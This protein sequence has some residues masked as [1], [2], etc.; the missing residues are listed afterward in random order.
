MKKLIKFSDFLTDVYFKNRK[1]LAE[2]TKSNL[3]SYFKN[4]L[5]FYNKR[6]LFI[7]KK[8]ILTWLE[9]EN[10]SY[11]SHRMN[12]NLYYI[13]EFAKTHKY[14]FKN[15]CEK[16]KVKASNKAGK[17]FTKVEIEKILS[18][19]KQNCDKLYRACLLALYGGLRRAEICGLKWSEVNTK[20]C[21]IIISGQI[22]R[23]DA[24]PPHFTEILKTESSHRKI[25]FPKF[26]IDELLLL[27]DNDVYVIGGFKYSFLDPMYITTKFRWVLDWLGLEHRRFHDLRHTNASILFEQ[28]V[29]QK[30][31]STRLGHAKMSTTIDVYTHLLNVQQ[32]EANI[33]L[34]KYLQ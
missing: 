33:A 11:N 20:S 31:I 8:D 2:T 13:F 24:K 10:N 34:Q 3:H 26:V 4:R 21:E 23:V 1:D 15:P 19:T 27:K 12:N 25:Q 22:V 5:D 29:N 18:Y 7:N 14:I 9:K 30:L 28:G 17:I 16:L 32:E 6:M